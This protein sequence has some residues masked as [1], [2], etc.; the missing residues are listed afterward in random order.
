MSAYNEAGTG[1]K[2]MLESNRITKM[3]LSLDVIIMF[4][5]L[6]LLLISSIS[7]IGALLY[8]IAFWG[9]L[10][11][12]VLTFANQKSQMLFIGLLGYALANAISFIL[13]LFRG[14]GFGWY[15]LIAIAIFGTLG[16][17]VMKQE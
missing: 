9:F 8:A 16:Y 12:V 4:A 2:G 13:D 5:G 15:D 11:G 3:L 17:L 1:V 14:W 7:G 10:I 6:A